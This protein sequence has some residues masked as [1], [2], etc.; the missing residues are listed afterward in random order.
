MRRSTHA[1]A[2]THTH[3]HTYRVCTH[4]HTYR[5][6]THDARHT[7]TR[8]A[9]AHTTRVTRRD[10]ARHD[11]TPLNETERQ[12]VKRVAPGLLEQLRRLAENLTVPATSATVRNLTRLQVFQR[13][14]TAERHHAAR[15]F[16]ERSLFQRFIREPHFLSAW[17]VPSACVR[18]RSSVWVRACLLAFCFAQP[19]VPCCVLGN[20]VKR[21]S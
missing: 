18:S 20:Y 15:R 16:A 6:G 1:Q 13:W 3:A 2:R 8:T 19:A 5:V 21:V 9:C 12:Q 7:L 14:I 4:T 11:N 17:C 10:T